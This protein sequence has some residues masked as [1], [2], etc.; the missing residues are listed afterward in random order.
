M[1]VVDDLI[2]AGFSRTQSD[3]IIGV[4]AGT[5]NAN[6]LVTQGVWANTAATLVAKNAGTATNDDLV[7]AGLSNPQ[8]TAVNAAFAVTP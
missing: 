1:A 8:V 6:D 7:R 3:A 5:A 2:T 4:D